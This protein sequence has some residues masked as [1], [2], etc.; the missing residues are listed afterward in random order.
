M[1]GN[2]AIVKRLFDACM[3]KDFDTVRELVDS[4]Y[5]LKD[6]MMEVHGVD[7]LVKMIESCPSDGKIE[8]L[9]IYADGD[10]VIS[11]FDGTGPDPKA[12]MRMC[13]IVKIENG[14]IKSEEMFY[15]T[16]KIPPEMKE[17]MKAGAPKKAA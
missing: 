5:T 14:K 3:A 13:S 16:A 15:D 1:T 4:G 2:T 7:E 9:K 10:T 11:T 17:Q 6:P 12:S 8:N